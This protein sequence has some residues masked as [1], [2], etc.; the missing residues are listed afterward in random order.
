MSIDENYASVAAL[1]KGLDDPV[2]AAEVR[3][4]FKALNH[5][6]NHSHVNGE[7]DGLCVFEAMALMLGQLTG[8]LSPKERSD[9]LA[10]VMVRADQFAPMFSGAGKAASH[11]FER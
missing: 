7:Q 10:Y 5:A 8:A 1:A 6:L 4:H 2:R 9:F 11:L 3:R